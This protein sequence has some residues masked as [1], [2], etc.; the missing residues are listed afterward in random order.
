MR[1]LFARF[2]KHASALL[3]L[4]VASVAAHQIWTSAHSLLTP[5]KGGG[6]GMYTAPHI[7]ARQV[8]LMLPTGHAVRLSPLTETT[9]NWVNHMTP[10]SA[11]YLWALA[12][13]AD[14]FRSYPTPD[15]ATALLTRAAR[16]AWADSLDP[17]LGLAWPAADQPGQRHAPESLR[18]VVTELAYHPVAGTMEQ[19]VLFTQTGEASE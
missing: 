18:L 17:A 13:E 15:T 2:P 6:F 9:E 7:L 4:L 16:V 10:N 12:N 8:W 14:R 19:K 3:A 5:W 11:A 1:R